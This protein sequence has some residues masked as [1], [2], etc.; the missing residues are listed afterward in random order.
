MPRGATRARWSGRRGRRAAT[1]IDRPGLADRGCGQ[2]G[3]PPTNNGQRDPSGNRMDLRAMTTRNRYYIE[4]FGCQMN[5]NDSEKV[6]GLLEA[7]GYERA[8]SAAAADFVFINTC[9]VREK[10]A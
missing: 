3:L 7:E 4:T 8:G 9:A 10:A 1:K 6:A 5:V 2:V